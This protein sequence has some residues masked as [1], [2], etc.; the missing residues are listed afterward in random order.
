[1]DEFSLL[2]YSCDEKIIV[3]QN[4]LI[5]GSKSVAFLTTHRDD[6]GEKDWLIIDN[7][8][9]EASLRETRKI[10]NGLKIKP[11]CRGIGR[12]RI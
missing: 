7:L 4:N 11:G 5:K 2:F 10:L 3:I 6:I 12:E 1:M 9:D 8:S